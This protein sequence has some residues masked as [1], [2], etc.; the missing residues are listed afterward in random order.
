[1]KYLFC[2]IP[3]A[4]IKKWM[5]ANKTQNIPAQNIPVATS[6]LNYLFFKKIFK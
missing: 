2:Y 1:M 6:F 4:P 5:N 3:Q